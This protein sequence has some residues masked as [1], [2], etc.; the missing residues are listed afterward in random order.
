[1]GPLP[2]SKAGYAYLLVIQ[3]T[4][5]KWIECCPLRHANGKSISQSIREQVISRWGAPEALLTDNGTEFIN[6]DLKALVAETGMIHITT[7]PYHPQSN[8]VERVNRV[9]KTMMVA[10]LEE[11]HRE[12]DSY[13]GDFRFAYN[14]AYHAS[15]QATPAFLNSGREPRIAV[16]RAPTPRGDVTIDPQT[17]PA[18]GERMQKLTQLRE[19]VVHNLQDAFQKQANYYNAGRRKNQFRVGDMILKRQFILFAGTQPFAAKLA[20]K[21]HG[22][23]RITNRLSNL[24]YE[25]STLNGQVVGKGMLKTSNHTTLLTNKLISH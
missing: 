13:L 10:F 14:T 8:P 6:R 2:R 7:P 24:V 18:W 9:L 12:W 17:P 11:D 15:L 1:M 3:D 5:S 25:V 4:F 19:R 23:F 22:P 16:P 21:Y 20:P